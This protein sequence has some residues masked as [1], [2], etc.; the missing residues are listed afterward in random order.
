MRLD[1]EGKPVMTQDAMLP[2]DI[3]FKALTKVVE[4]L[5]K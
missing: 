5:G 1:E 2:G 4:T 3:A